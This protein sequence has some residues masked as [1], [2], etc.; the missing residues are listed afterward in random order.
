MNK[1]VLNFIT[2]EKLKYTK[3]IKQ[4]KTTLFEEKTD[5]VK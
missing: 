5:Y 4:L 2:H 1:G 3:L